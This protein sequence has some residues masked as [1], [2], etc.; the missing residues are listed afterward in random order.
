VDNGFSIYPAGYLEKTSK[1]KKNGIGSLIKY[2]FD[3][4]RSFKGESLRF[5]IDF[6]DIL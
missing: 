5:R 1:E 4:K 2:D 6:K 3:D